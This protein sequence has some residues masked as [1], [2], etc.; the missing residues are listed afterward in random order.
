MIIVEK[1]INNCSIA[2]LSYYDNCFTDKKKGNE[3]KWSGS[4]LL[5]IAFKLIEKIKDR[6]KI[7]TV[8]LTDNE[9]KF[10]RKGK[11]IDLLLT[12]NLKLMK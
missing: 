12:L 10:C 5:K 1:D 3:S 6:Y 11:Q 9:Q 8:T 2:G 4:D 7:K